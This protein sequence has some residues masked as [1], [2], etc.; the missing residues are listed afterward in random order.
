M[1]LLK[2]HEDSNTPLESITDLCRDF[3]HLTSSSEPE[4]KDEVLIKSRNQRKNLIPQTIQYIVYPIQSWPANKL[5]V[6]KV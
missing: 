6:P 4:Q 1:K 3:K 5:K 2:F